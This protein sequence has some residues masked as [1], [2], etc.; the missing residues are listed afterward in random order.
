MVAVGYD[1]SVIGGTMALDSFRRDFG[2]VSASET[3]TDTLEGNIV[4]TFQ[5]GCFFGSL[6]TFPLGERFGRR[7]AIIMA[8]CVFCVGGSLMVRLSC[9]Q[10]FHGLTIYMIDCIFRP[11]R[12]DICWPRRCRVRHRGCITPGP[13]LHS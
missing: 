10:C 2:L 7:N 4:S 6:L 1:T 8:V 5:A 11:S 13:G 3:E 9:I 12:F